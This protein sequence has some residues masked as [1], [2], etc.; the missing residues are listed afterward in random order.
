VSAPFTRFVCWQP[1]RIGIVINKEALSVDR[2]NFLA[3]HVPLQQIT[4]EKSPRHIASASEHELLEELCRQAD[5]DEHTF[6]VIRGAPGTGKSHLIRWLKERYAV[7]RPHERVLLIER[8]NSSLRGTLQQIIRSNLFDSV[9]LPDQ[10]RRLEDAVNALSADALADNLLNQ[11]QVATGEVTY[12]GELPNRLR[13][14]KVEKFLLD[15]AVRERLKE[16]GGPIERIANFLTAGQEDG[17]GLDEA[18]GFEAADFDFKPDFLRTVQGYIEAKHLAEDLQHRSELKDMLAAYLNYLL[19]EYAIK[20]AT[21][22]STQDL[23]DL[24]GDL[25]RHL[26]QQGLSLAL[27]IEDITAFTGIDEGLIDVLIT[28]HRSQSNAEFCRLTSVI[29]VT[30][31]YFNAHFLENVRHRI[32]HQL[33]LNARTNR[34]EE[35]DMM[36]DERVRAQFAARYLNALRLDQQTLDSWLSQ[37][38]RPDALPNACDPCPFRLPC[39]RA[40]GYVEL[41]DDSGGEQQRIG[42]YPFNQTA[43]GRLYDWLKDELSRT[44]R[45][46]LYEL[47]A[48]ILQSHTTK[49]EAGEFP[50]PETDLAPV[51]ALPAFDPP[52]H[53]NVVERQAGRDA[54]RMSTMLLFWGNRNAFRRARG[55]QVGGVPD[56]ALMAFD[57]P[58][59]DGQPILGLDVA[60]VMPIG[61]AGAETPSS[62]AVSEYTALINDW[63]GGKALRRYDRLAEWLALL[64]QS[65]VDWQAHG[66]S[67][68]QVREYI[69]QARFVIEGQTGKSQRTHVLKFNRSPELRDTFQ[70]LADLNDSAVN[71]TPEQY[72]E[73]LATLSAWVRSEEARIVAFVREP[74]GHNPAP[75]Y[76]LGVLVRD[77]VLLACLGGELEAD[78]DTFTLYHQVIASCAK[79]ARW[80]ERIEATKDS[81]PV[82]WRDLMR[83]VNNQDGVSTC[84]KELLQLIN[85]PQGRSTNVLYVDAAAVIEPLAQFQNDDWSLPPVA[86]QPKTTDET[87]NAA[88]QAHLALSAGFADAVQSSIDELS[89]LTQSVLDALSDDTPDTT[90]TAI[91]DTLAELR[92]VGGYDAQLDE[93]FVAG[94]GV[95]LAPEL[96]SRLLMDADCLISDESFQNRASRVSQAYA[97]LVQGLRRFVKYFSLVDKTFRTRAQVL[98]TRVEAA[99][100]KSDGEQSYAAAIVCYEQL[101]T[102]LESLQPKQERQ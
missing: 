71:L 63:M 49:V 6:A 83:R 97:A 69:T 86:I 2:A 64:V 77:A 53:R 31:A 4:Y 96:L 40:F 52:A 61:D 81:H 74:E 90:L 46:F 48:Y 21:R 54:G 55:K 76:L 39:H 47:L 13:P 26:H 3:T 91:K 80:T 20:R 65:F 42:L 24:F 45:T 89:R 44:P 28:Q 29:G 92:N 58:V 27:F 60:P 9:A 88:I 12:S 37:D 1:E 33:T 100:A 62:P 85:C 18:P 36:R 19:R 32:S 66:I 10:L 35:S 99:R 72:G 56:E 8:A 11:L 34:G 68:T 43:L 84:R 82:P 79:N 25:R 22:L 67:A 94:S 98:A 41:D 87:W 59:I 7:E 23:R 73:H 75:D 30:D 70:A 95:Q 15:F 101:D 17:M 14:A 16:P 57:L 50:P 38:A 5:A 93:P 78:S 51:L 102:L